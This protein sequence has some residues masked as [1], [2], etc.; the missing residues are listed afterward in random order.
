MV[1]IP[2]D[3]EPRMAVLVRASSSLTDLTNQQDSQ[4]SHD[5]GVVRQQNM[6]ISPMGSGTE[7]DC[8]GEGQQQFTQS[9][10]QTGSRELAV[11]NYKPLLGN[12]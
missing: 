1:R 6:V 10:D 3:P 7:N 8:A 4:E 11:S 9:T 12:C 5:S 2:Q